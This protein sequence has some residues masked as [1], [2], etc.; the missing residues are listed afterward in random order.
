[1]LLSR[2]PIKRVII[3]SGPLPPI[4]PPYV[5]HNI[6]LYLNQ[7]LMQQMR[8]KKMCHI[9]LPKGRG[10]ENVV[11]VDVGAAATAGAAGG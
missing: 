1:M 3:L 6:T 9:A 4:I 10:F 5:R 11:I 7:R 8:L 2:C